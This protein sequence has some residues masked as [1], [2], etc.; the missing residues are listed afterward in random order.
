MVRWAL[1]IVTVISSSH[2]V[3]QSATSAQAW[4]SRTRLGFVYGVFG[5]D[6]YKAITNKSTAL[7]GEVSILKGTWRFANLVGKIRGLYI[8]GK[9]DFMD[10]STA[11][12]DVSYTLFATE[13][14][15]GIH[16]NIMPYYPPG[17]RAYLLGLGIMSYDHIR[18]DK[19]ITFTTINNSDTHIGYGFELGAGLEWN[20]KREKSMWS[21]WGEIQYRDVTTNLLG[22]EKFKL[23]GLQMVGGIGW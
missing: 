3:A 9:E 15:I 8:S 4:P 11:H 1:L 20:I 7:G 21:M 16:L 6:K 10:G 18:L 2:A 17:I 13:P 22:Q 14:C 5:G 12:T 19:D 23:T